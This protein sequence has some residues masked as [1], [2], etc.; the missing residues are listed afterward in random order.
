MT[1]GSASVDPASAASYGSISLWDE[2]NDDALRT[3]AA[4]VHEHG[5]LIMSQMTHMGRRGNSLMSGVPLRAVSDLPEG[6]HRE[7]PVV[8]STA[9]IS[10]L[11]ERFADAA[12]RLMVL[13]WDGAEV[14][15]LG[16]H[17]I[18]QFFDPS[19]NDRTDRYGGSLRESRPVRPG[20]A[21]AVREAT[22]DDFILSFRMTADQSIPDGGLTPADLAQVAQAITARRHGRRAEHRQRH[23]LHR[24]DQ[25]SFRTRRRIADQHQRRSRWADEAG[26][27]RAGSGGGA[28]PRR[29]D[30]RARA[31]RG[32]RRLRRHD[33]GPDRR[34][35]SSAQEPRPAVRPARASA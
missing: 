26:H 15:S 28:D 3:L 10:G 12:R 20:G 11:V 6:V 18:E 21:Q 13:G 16:G 24:A 33:S 1:F 32:R 35:G 19:V 25:F 7:V 30:G 29:G 2:R 22:S 5:A 34:S 4:R 9:E 17:L 8:L 23:R 14:T 27:R 31:D